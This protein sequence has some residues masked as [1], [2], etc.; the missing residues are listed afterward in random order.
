MRRLIPLI[1]IAL[2][3]ATD[4]MALTSPLSGSW[5]LSSGDD[6]GAEAVGADD[7]QWQPVTVPHTWNNL[8]GQDG[9]NNYL[10]TARWY[11]QHFAVTPEMAGK[12][13]FVRFEGATRRPD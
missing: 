6:T 8:D 12:S 2:A 9:G 11:R 3:I 5:K 4:A 13:L 10:K 7:S 1:S